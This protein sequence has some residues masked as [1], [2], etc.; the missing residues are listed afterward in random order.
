MKRVCASIAVSLSVRMDKGFAAMLQTG[1][2]SVGVGDTEQKE[3]TM[4]PVIAGMDD[5]R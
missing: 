4:E 2:E 5:C 3:D 1:G